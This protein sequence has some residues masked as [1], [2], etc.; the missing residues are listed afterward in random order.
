[1]Q[2]STL[3]ETLN[4]DPDSEVEDTWKIDPEAE[5][6]TGGDPI[7]EKAHV[8]DSNAT[9]DP[10]AETEGEP[11]TEKSHVPDSNA[12]HIINDHMYCLKAD[13]DLDDGYRLVQWRT[14]LN[15]L[16]KGCSACYSQLHITDLIHDLQVGL[17]GFLIVKC[18][19]CL[20]ANRCP[21][22]PQHSIKMQKVKGK[23]NR[24]MFEINTRL[25]VGKRNLI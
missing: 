25:G 5:G 22:G 21:Y 19:N 9:H 16:N 4:V 15:S 1:M 23:R 2:R 14:L 18:W 20:K 7:T 13:F 3:Q 24:K 6:E 8:P 17:A 10:E 12:T 11:N